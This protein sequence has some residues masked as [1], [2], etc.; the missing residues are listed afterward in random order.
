VTTRSRHAPVPDRLPPVIVRTT[1]P[2]PRLAVVG[3]AASGIAAAALLSTWATVESVFGPRELRGLDT[4]EGEIMIACVAAAALCFLLMLPMR[5]SLLM[6]P[7]LIASAL[8]LGLGITVLSDPS[9]FVSRGGVLATEIEPSW[10][11][12]GVVACGVVMVFCAFVVG[13]D[14]HHG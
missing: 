1:A 8:L 10:G 4:V 12:Y 9:G 5:A 14:H 11:M 6:V 2:L 13:W 3:L 7:A